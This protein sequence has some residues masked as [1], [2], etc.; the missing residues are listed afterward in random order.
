MDQLLADM[1]QSTCNLMVLGVLL[2]VVY[3]VVQQGVLRGR[4]AA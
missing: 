4:S 2:G 1:S 3:A